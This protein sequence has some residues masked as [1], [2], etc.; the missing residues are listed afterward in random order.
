MESIWVGR[1]G[2]DKVD[3]NNVFQNSANLAE[4][5]EALAT[6]LRLDR[7][8]LPA[9]MSGLRKSGGGRRFTSLCRLSVQVAIV[10]APHLSGLRD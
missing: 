3:D 7:S 6:A 1:E 2:V 4:K 9:S 10:A 8:L 5:Q